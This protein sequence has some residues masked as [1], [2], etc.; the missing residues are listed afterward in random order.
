VPRAD[1]DRIL[2]D[3][4][5]KE[6]AVVHEGVEV[7]DVGLR[8]DGVRLTVEVGG[9]ATE[10]VEAAFLVDASGRDALIASRLGRHVP[11]LDLGKAAL[12]AHY[13]G[14]RRAS[15]RL[16]AISR[17]TSSTSSSRPGRPPR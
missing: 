7:R 6:G 10:E 4:A 9:G 8:N 12:F 16:E 15:G 11:L 5:T 14:A 17:P 1:F 2:L 13:R 3:H